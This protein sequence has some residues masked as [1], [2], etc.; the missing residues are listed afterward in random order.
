MARRQRRKRAPERAPPALL[1]PERHREEP[2]HAGIE[3]VRGAQEQQ[4]GAGVEIQ[5]GHAA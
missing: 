3:P 4:R 1:Q 5:A 2:S